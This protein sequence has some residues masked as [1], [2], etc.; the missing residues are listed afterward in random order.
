MVTSALVS[1]KAFD[2]FLPLMIDKNDMHSIDPKH[3]AF[4]R[5]YSV[6]LSIS[7]WIMLPD[8]HVHLTQL[9]RGMP[10]LS[11]TASQ[12][13]ID[14]FDWLQWGSTA[15]VCDMGCSDG[16][17]MSL[18]KSKHPTLRITCQDLAPVLPVARQVCLARFFHMI[19]LG[20]AVY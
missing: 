14:G 6:P 18:L 13:V 4:S 16:G 5:A 15:R 1:G 12:G 20:V 2:G 8:N 17:I 11:E 19:Y 10:W 9:V 3:G 7:D